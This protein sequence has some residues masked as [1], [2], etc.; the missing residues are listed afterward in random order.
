MSGAEKPRTL[1]EY[2]GRITAGVI[3]F[4][5]SLALAGCGSKAH[6][7]GSTSAPAANS[8]QARGNT[9][10]TAKAPSTTH[11]E[12]G[13]DVSFPQCGGAMPKG[14]AFAIVGL[15][16]QTAK[17]KNPCLAIE[18][19][20]AARSTG[21]TNQ[22]KVELYVDPAAPGNVVADWPRS[23]KNVYGTCEK[24]DG[25][26]ADSEACADQYGQNLAAYDEH[27]I[28]PAKL[29]KPDIWIDA[30]TA[31]SW[32]FTHPDIDDAVLQGMISNF[33]AKGATVGVYSNASE[34]EKIAGD[35]SRSK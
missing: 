31:Y 27:E 22:P 25:K 6:A 29:V 35:V 24:V 16:H 5:G 13:N 9:T 23:G 12:F 7:E 21:D 1:L 33:N 32:D 11:T 17:T 26:G 15:N 2:A 20:W 10:P 4:G 3:M 18:L 28:K 14:Q 19:Q 34:W 30:E 8:T